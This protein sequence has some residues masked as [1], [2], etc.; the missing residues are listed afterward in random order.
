[1]E[2]QHS[3]LVSGKKT[4]TSANWNVHHLARVS[5]LSTTMCGPFLRRS[6]LVLILVSGFYRTVKF[7]PLVS[8]VAE[9]QI[10]TWHYSIVS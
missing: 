10:A 2:Q 9:L 3:T 5:I 1:M 4:T 7:V 6:V 8:Q